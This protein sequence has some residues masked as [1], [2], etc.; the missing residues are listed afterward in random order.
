MNGVASASAAPLGPH[1]LA[2]LRVLVENQGRV[3]GRTEIARRAG[4]A[5]LNQRRCDSILVT[6]RRVLGVAAIRTVRSR[7]WM[8]EPD[9]IAIA[10]ALLS[11]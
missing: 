4:L 6:L 2:V 9:T 10:V 11:H 8:L 1:D 7:G 5:D 3:I